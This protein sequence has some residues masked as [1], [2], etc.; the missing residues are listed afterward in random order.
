MT[1]LNAIL[2]KLILVV[3]TAPAWYP[4]LKAVWEEMN[5]AMADEG[6]VLGR[7]PSARELEAVEREKSGWE[8]P[9]VHEAWPTREERV[10]GRRRLQER[11]AR[12]AGPTRP[13]ARQ[14]GTGG[15][16]RAGRGFH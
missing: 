9:L 7:I 5:K 11:G 6:G 4:F 3:V 16:R 8:D 15:A 12:G 10:A 1:E 2:L 13:A 14:P